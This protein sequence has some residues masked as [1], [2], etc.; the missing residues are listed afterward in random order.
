M[1]KKTYFPQKSKEQ[2]KTPA[3]TRHPERLCFS[4]LHLAQFSRHKHNDVIGRN[5]LSFP[6]CGARF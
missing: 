4:V 1:H 6:G 3:S 2:N 5:T